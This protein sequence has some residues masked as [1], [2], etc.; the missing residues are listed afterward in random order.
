MERISRILVV[1]DDESIR[2]GLSRV[3]TEAGYDVQ[4][5]A[6]AESAWSKVVASG[7]P[8]LVITDLTLPG[9]SG[10]DLIAAVRDRGIE[11]TIV[12]LTGT[13]SIASAVEATR[14][15]VYDYLVKPVDAPRTAVVPR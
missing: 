12:V 1:D 10:M 11:V 7:G 2:R 9:K 5:A 3:L 14:R 8:D 6:D 4:V 13:G 15:G